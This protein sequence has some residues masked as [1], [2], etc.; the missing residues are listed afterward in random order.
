METVVK[1]KKWGNSVG[2]IL[3]AEF[4]KQQHIHPGDDLVIDV[5]EKHNVLK[6]L[7]GALP[8]KKPTEQLLK[9]SRKE[10]ESKWMR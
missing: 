1:T 8:F 2:V 5:K 7:F 4:V 3:P 6:E 10:L 9:E